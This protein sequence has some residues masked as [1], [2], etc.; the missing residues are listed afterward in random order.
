MRRFLLLALFFVVLD[1]RANVIEAPPI[2]VDFAQNPSHLEWRHIVTE[3]FDIIFPHDIEDEA[4]R[5]AH[6]LE[7]AYPYVT[8]SLETR[9]PRIPLILQNQSTTSNGFVTL[10][11]RRSEWYVTP[12]VD[13]VLTNTEWLKTL[14]IHEFRHVVQFHKTRQGFNIALEILLGEIGQALG[15]GLTLPPWFLEGDAVGMETALTKGGRGR[16]PLFDRDLRTLLLSDKEWNYDKAHLGSYEDYVPNHYVYGYFYTSWL[17]NEYGDLF[18]S[19]LAD[20]SAK[21]SWNPLNF[22][23]TTESLTGESFERFYRNVMRDLV[24]EWKTRAAELSPTPYEVLSKGK[25]FGWTNYLYP[26]LSEEGK[27]FALKKGLSH[28][29]QFVLINE[30]KEKT[31]FYPSSLQSEYPFKLRKN[32]FAFFENEMD[33]RWGYRDYSRLRVYDLNEE[34]FILDTRKTKGRL[35]V[36]DHEGNRVLYVD[37]K[38]DQGQNIVV[39]SL[40]GKELLRFPFP[41]KEV[42]TS[43]DWIDEENIVMIIK[44]DDD[45]KSMIRLNLSTW[46]REVL[47]PNAVTNLGFLT[48]NEGEILY[49]SPES[50]IDNIWLYTENGTR[51]ITSSLYGAYAPV[52]SGGKL[53]YNDYSASGMD[54]VSKS[55]PFGEEQKS[56]GSFY[57]IYEKFAKSEN[58][59]EFS[60]ELLDKKTYT[61]QKYSQPKNAFNLH[62][63]TILAPPLSNTITLVGYSRDILNNFNLTA[64]AEYHLG[65]RVGQIFVSGLWSHYYPLFDL[66]AG[67]GGRR[68]EFTTPEGEKE[69]R[70]E[71]GTIE[72]GIQVPWK[73]LQGRFTHQFTVRAFSKIIKV[74]NKR[75]DDLSDINDGALHSPGAE[76]S[77]SA[78]SRM[79]RRDLNPQFGF[80]LFM[81]AEEGKD[82]TGTDQAG[83]LKHLDS[84]LY[85]P[86]LW[87][88]HS[89]Y[90]QLAYERQRDDLY[91]YS[92]LVLYPRGTRSVFLQEFAKYSG[93][94]LLPLFYPD[95]NLSRYLYFKRISLNLFYDELN[96]RFSGMSYR[97]ASYGWETIF[98]MHFLRIFL[99]FSIGV[100]GSYVIDGLDKSSNYELFLTTV[101][102]TF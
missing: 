97:A 82:I 7:K 1:V 27:I 40:K 8:R 18:L 41:K 48:V 86:G 10:A 31:L 26:Q 92:S 44:D 94:Y 2:A 50:G 74:V 52:L 93:N 67:Y 60:S 15:L 34:K 3:H 78:F 84:R 38:P 32:R 20:E 85:L 28:I 9:P 87:Y 89:F 72:A 5:V 55:L 77:Y 22:Y 75:A 66:R 73:Y 36:I 19:R 91:Q 56:E 39:T 12:A 58:Y 23:L 43:M 4:Q 6:L 79:A 96:G 49:E 61:S 95:Y 24:S 101:L 29:P 80:S 65:E 21:N 102:G 42:I 16:L 68:E 100:R 13:P 64:G 45:Q 30:S 81:K 59:S 88:H 69:H 17:R 98:E 46:N 11:P 76:L 53:Y 14:S 57:P 54:I 35:A 90:H 70:W 33:P 51:Q 37:W 99:P 71:E 62:S 25:R 83:S 63:W 47:I